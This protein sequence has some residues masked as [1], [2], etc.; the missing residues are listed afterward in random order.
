MAVRYG[1]AAPDRRAADAVVQKG[2]AAPE[3]YALAG[4]GDFGFNH[5]RRLVFPHRFG[6]DF[7]HLNSA[8]RVL[9]VSSDKYI[10]RQ[11]LCNRS[12]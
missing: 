3:D 5:S 9:G 10:L 6:R 2:S 4:L 11:F 1:S 8:A 7:P 12:I